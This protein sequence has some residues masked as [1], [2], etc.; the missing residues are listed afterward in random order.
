M[1]RKADPLPLDA[2]LKWN[3][4]CEEQAIRGTDKAKAAEYPPSCYATP[5]S[6]ASPLPRL[7]TA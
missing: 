4:P 7:L 5:E 6:P 3:T 2:N 1:M